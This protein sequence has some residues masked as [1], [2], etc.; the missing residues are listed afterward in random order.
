MT[1]NL[2]DVKLPGH[3]LYVLSECVDD[4]GLDQSIW[5]LGSGIS[6]IDKDFIESKVDFTI[7]RYLAL[8]AAKMAD[9]PAIGL[10]IGK[11]LSIHSHGILG[12]AALNSATLRDAAQLIESYISIRF[13]LIEVHTQETDSDFILIVDEQ[14]PLGDVKQFVFDGVLL[15]IKMALEQLVPDYIGEHLTVSFKTPAHEG[16]PYQNVFGCDVKFN[17]PFDG[18]SGP[19]FLMSM[20]IPDANSL[21]YQ[22]A[23]ALCRKE[24]E[25][26]TQDVSLTARVKKKLLEVPGEFASLEVVSSYFNMTPRTLHRRLK[27]EGLSYKQILEDVKASLALSY[28]SNSDMSI[29]EIAFF[30]G[31]EDLSNFRRAFKRWQGITPSAYRSQQKIV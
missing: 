4:F 2:S 31:Y 27:E 25:R 3:Y 9:N 15:T 18:L 28:L 10:A 23:E 24:F 21:A 20:E 19:L 17:Q 7:F 8:K 1:L 14:V 29:K 6:K 16:F 22:E 30:L 5:L 11:R 12:Y 13:P 26:I